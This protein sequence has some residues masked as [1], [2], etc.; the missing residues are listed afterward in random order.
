MME[1]QAEAA[2]RAA[3]TALEAPRKR[4]PIKR[5]HYRGPSI[6]VTVSGRPADN[7]GPSVIVSVT[8]KTIS[9][10]EAEMAAM[11][12]ASDQRLQLVVVTR[13]ERSD[14]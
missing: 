13:I 4:A 5:Q 14:P 7:R 9:A 2:L 3:L 12:E 1:Y 10:F 11:K 8:T 6:T